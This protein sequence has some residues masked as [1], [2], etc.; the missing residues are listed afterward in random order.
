MARKKDKKRKKAAIKKALIIPR[1]GFVPGSV[2]RPT[3]GLVR[4][5]AEKIVRETLKDSGV[6]I[7]KVARTLKGARLPTAIE[8]GQKIAGTV[9]SVASDFVSGGSSSERVPFLETNQMG[10]RT[11]G[12]QEVKRFTTNFHYGKPTPRTLRT[13][14]KQNGTTKYTFRDTQYDTTWT[15]GSAGRD[16]LT[17]N[18]G[19]NRKVLVNY[20]RWAIEVEDLYDVYGLAN[21]STP[22]NRLQTNYA[23]ILNLWK[24]LTIMNTSRYLKAKYTLKLYKAV[25]PN[26]VISSVMNSCLQNDAGLAVGT[27]LEN[28]LPV[29]Y[30][31]D[32]VV[33]EG[34][35]GATKV[36]V[37]PKATML[38]AP[39]FAAN[40]EF[41]KSFTK[42]LGPG[43]AWKYK[44]VFHTGSG[45][46]IDAMHAARDRYNPMEIGHVMVLEITGQEVA[47][48]YAP[49]SNENFIGTSPVYCQ[50]EFKT[51]GEF[52][53]N[54]HNSNSAYVS[55][56]SGGG[57]VSTNFLVRSFT[58]HSGTPASTT[59]KIF[60]V[61]M[62]KITTDPTDT[63]AGKLF[64][65]IMSDQTVQ[66]A[67]RA[68]Q[69]GTGGNEN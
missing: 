17:L 46:N 24:H 65:P 41:V 3:W 7:D 51:G 62:S 33:A 26:R 56:G 32:G 52:V 5:T 48:C 14:A 21:Y 2:M 47:A 59:T 25:N 43:D 57:V 58:N 34:A 40:Y 63:A 67:Q 23:C 20:R 38:D 50:I 30:Q 68:R 45:I 60:N 42:W 15:A 16:H 27:N 6:D 49:N 61:P 37:D 8:A 64:I 31:L 4:G 66:Y 12:S 55:T 13:I 18:G 35:D 44:E 53:N 29:R 54:P 69:G 36:W 10:T 22:A 11:V 28:Y 9:Y 19:F 1:G 39:E